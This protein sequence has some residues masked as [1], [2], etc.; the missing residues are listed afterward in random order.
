MSPIR[1]LL[2]VTDFSP[3]AAHAVRRAALLAGAHGARLVLLHVV[4][5]DGLVAFRDWMSRGRDL[6]AAVEEQAR[7]QLEACASQ[8]ERQQGVAV[9]RQIRLG[10]AVD[11]V[12]AASAAADLV[13]VGS[14][15]DRGVREA[16]LGSF[17]DRLVRTAH[18][19]VL[20]VKGPASGA[21]TRPLALTDFSEAARAALN[22]TLAVADGATVQLLHAFELPFEGK[23]R[24]AGAR[25]E[26]IAAYREEVRTRLAGQMQQ[27]QAE[28]DAPGRVLPGIVPG[29]VRVE[30]LRAFDRLQPDLVAVGKQGDSLLEDMLLGSTTSS[31][32]ASAPCDVLV[33]PRRA[34]EG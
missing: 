6:R 28:S 13:V 14:R 16:A 29:D 32:L 12:H 15:G 2:A 5:P 9:E 26:D 33:V 18:R 17:A 27:A 20:V 10:R 7:M 19:P 3:D 8:V 24:L 21:Y 22:A 34:G 23:L 1:T 31:M 11:V 4:E 25:D 30:A